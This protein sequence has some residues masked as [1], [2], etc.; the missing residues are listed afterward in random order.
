MTEPLAPL[1]GLL[2]VLWC[3]LFAVKFLDE[4]PGGKLSKRITHTL[5][6]L[7]LF[8]PLALLFHYSRR[9]LPRLTRR[10]RIPLPGRK[11]R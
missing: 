7:L 10:K 1:L 3:F 6:R 9:S 8:K 4:A 11:R 2:L 5:L